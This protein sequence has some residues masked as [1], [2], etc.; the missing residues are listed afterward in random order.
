M[1]PGRVGR[2][3][4]ARETGLRKV[5]TPQSR[6]VGNSHPGRPA[7]QCHR[8]QTARPNSR[9]RVKRWCKRPPVHRVTGVAR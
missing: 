6:V 1:L 9:V 3:I 4:A 2:V 7:G 8:E 5:R